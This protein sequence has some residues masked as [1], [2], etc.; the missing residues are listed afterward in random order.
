[1]R[2]ANGAEYTKEKR[3]G[4]KPALGLLTLVIVR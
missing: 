4:G 1:L 3:A 2:K